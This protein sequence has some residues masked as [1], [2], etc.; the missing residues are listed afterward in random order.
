VGRYTLKEIVQGKPM[1]HPSHPMFVH[2]PAAYYVA[3][4]GFDVLSRAGS[5]PAAPVAATWLIAGS[6]LFWIPLV[7]TG[8]VDW[9]GM[10]KGGKARHTAN[11]HLLLQLMAASLFLVALILRWPD[12]EIAEAKTI[13]IALEAVGT[14][15]MAAGNWFG[16]ILV[17][18]MSMR[19]GEMP[20][21]KQTPASE[22]AAS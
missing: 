3:A 22:A 12:R 2:F 20:A 10:R 19:V 8:L 5:F 14:L 6:V 17:Y 15:L 21:P 11:R 9:A 4:L 1:G 16:G 7:V 13:W 18:R